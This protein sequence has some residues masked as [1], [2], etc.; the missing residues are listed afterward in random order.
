MLHALTMGAAYS[1]LGIVLLAVGFVVVDLLTPGSLGRHI[2]ER[3]SINAGIV[4]SSV[5]CALG[6]I[7]FTAIWT[8]GDGGDLVGLGWVAAFGVL[9]IVLQAVAFLVLDLLTP[10]SLREMVVER[11]LHPGALVAAAAMIAVGAVVCASIA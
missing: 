6:A 8:N 5:F 1:A 7:M 2:Y 9:G 3:R 4:V 10:G 11:E